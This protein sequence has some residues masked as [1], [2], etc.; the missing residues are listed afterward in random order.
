MAQPKDKEFYERLGVESSANADEIKKAYRKMAIRFHPDKNPDNPEA[1][2]KFKEI[3]EAYEVL[4]DTKKRDLYDKY[5]KEGLQE[6]GFHAGNASDLFSQFFGFGGGGRQGPPQG[7]DIVHP[8]NCTLEELY[9]GKSV[10]MGV[11]R[12]VICSKCTGTGSL[13]AGATSTCATCKGRGARIALRQFGP[14]MMQQMQIPC[15]DCNGTGEKIA[16]ADRCTECKGKKV[17]KEKKVLEVHI[18]KGMKHGQKITFTGESDQAPGTEPG[19]IIFVVQQKEHATFKRQDTDLSMEHTI[20]LIEALTG[21][22]FTV[23]HLDGRTLVVSTVPGD[24][25]TPGE[26]RAIS[27]EGMP[28]Y[29]RP[30]EKGDLLVKFNIV[31]PEPGKFTPQQAALLERILPPRNPL[32]AVV[33][34]DAEEVTLASTA[35]KP[36]ARKGQRNRGEAYSDDRMHDDDDEE[37]DGRQGGPGVNCRQQ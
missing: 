35:Y 28:T 27:G 12:D 7:E 19:D 8:V 36:D 5:G 29:K 33:S 17:V 26:V 13:R 4:S 9:K 31:F 2:D 20:P 1:A 11:T 30:F 37:D 18:D 21:T 14:G 34:D 10:K 3:S 24:V 22:K 25:L 6:G 15:G 23:T 32:P 16:D